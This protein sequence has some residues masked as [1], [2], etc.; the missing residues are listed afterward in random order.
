[1]RQQPW[2]G[3]MSVLHL[4]NH[5]QMA[6]LN[7]LFVLYL[8]ALVPSSTMLVLPRSIGRLRVNAGVLP[9]IVLRAPPMSSKGPSGTLGARAKSLKANGY[10]LGAWLIFSRRPLLIRSP[11]LPQ[12]HSRESSL[13]GACTLV[14]L[15]DMSTLFFPSHQWWMTHGSA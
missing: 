13:A 5:K 1:M 14:E 2:V 15:G 8:K 4:A 3:L 12:E 10:P 7:V 11:N 6:W 9:I